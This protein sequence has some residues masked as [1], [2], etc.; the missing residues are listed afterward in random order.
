MEAFAA[1]T[2]NDIQLLVLSLDGETVPDDPR[3]V[4][5]PY[6]FVSREE[7]NRRLVLADVIA[8]PFDPDGEMLTTGV[9]GDVVGLGLPAIISS[10]A[11]LT[12]T[13]GAAG[14]T[15]RSDAELIALLE[16]LSRA[17]LD[18]AAAASVRL[19]DDLAWDRIAAQFF[20]ALVDAGAIKV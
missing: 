20:A 5:L 8:L 17:D 18:R 7:Y 6:D 19:Q 13:L 10:W 15:Y 12:E 4:A 14:L 2:R 9:V 16:S 11:Y 1:T 3:I